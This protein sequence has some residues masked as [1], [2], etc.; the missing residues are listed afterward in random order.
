MQYF[1]QPEIFFTMRS[2]ALVTGER[3][4]H[5]NEAVKYA[6]EIFVLAKNF[7]HLIIL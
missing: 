3:I 6:N 2:T 5:K 1:I 4:M 7:P